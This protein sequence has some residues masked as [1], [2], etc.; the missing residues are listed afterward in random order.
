MKNILIILTALLFVA[1]CKHETDYSP[2]KINYDRDICA[3]C[4][5]GIAEKNYAVQAINKNGNVLWFDDIGCYVEY[6]DKPEWKKFAGDSKPKVWIADADTGEWLDIEKAWY[7]FGD[8][9]P[10]GFGYGAVKE[11]KDGYYDYATTVQ[12]IKEGKTNRE[13][14]IKKH[15]MM[16]HGEDSKQGKPAMK[17]APGKCGKDSSGKMKCGGAK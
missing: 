5:M 9:T 15:K 7:R 17:C 12:R 1:S 6:L 13:A 8:H 14:F 11:K 3:N 4:L 10:M 2:R 16:K